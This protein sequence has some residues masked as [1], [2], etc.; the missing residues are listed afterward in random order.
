MKKTKAVVDRFEG[1]FAVVLAESVSVDVPKKMI[2]DEVKEGGVIYI[3]IANDEEETKERDE[4]ARD[5]LNEVLQEE[6]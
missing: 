5:L 1:D 3:T 2:P 4:L 6:S